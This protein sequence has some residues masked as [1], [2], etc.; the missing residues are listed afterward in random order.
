MNNL[1]KQTKRITAGLL[2]LTMVLM[3]LTYAAG[4]IAK[5]NLMEKYPAPG[6]LINVDGFRM[7]IHCTGEGSPTVILAAG[8]DDFSIFWSQVQP[9]IAK[10][11]RVC[12]YDRAGLG[13][14][15]ASPSPRTSGNMVK[16]LHALLI[17]GGVDGPYV[18]VGHSF[19]GALTRLYAHQYP[20]EVAAMILVDAAPDELFIRVPNWDDAIQGKLGLY[21]TLAP[22][23]SFG[24]LAFT[25]QSIPNRGLSEDVLAQYR[26]IAVSTDYFQTGIAENEAFQDNLT[27]VRSANISLPD[28][29]LVVI[30]RGYWD[31][32]PGFSEAE[33]QQAWQM[34]QEMQAELLLLSSTSRHV[35]ATESEHHV[36]LQQPELIINSII[37]LMQGRQ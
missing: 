13:W 9:E 5:R 26:A 2:I 34:W 17:N 35:I 29:P 24:L 16:E 23:G 12:S 21:R 6:Q 37:D 15:E 1:W 32:I 14:S 18:M 30:S 11:T 22:L 10:V 19:G 27:E 8:L 31:A 20:G 28:M 3:T 33:N 25:P 4:A 7:Y 36:Q